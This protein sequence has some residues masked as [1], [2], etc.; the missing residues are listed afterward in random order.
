MSKAGCIRIVI[1]GTWSLAID[2]ST[3]G[4]RPSTLDKRM[5]LLEAKEALV[6]PVV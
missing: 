1:P 5:S 2:T 4:F 3:I 6:A